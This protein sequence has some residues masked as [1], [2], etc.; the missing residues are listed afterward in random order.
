MR[1]GSRDGV[2]T[3]IEEKKTEEQKVEI[4]TPVELKT[5]P[6]I[7]LGASYKV[8]TPV[9]TAF[10]TVN[11]DEN[12]YPFE[13]FI[14]VGK[15]G[16]DITADAEALGRLISL[17]FRIPSAYSPKA[18]AEEVVLQLRG[19]GGS[20]SM[21]FGNGRVR[22]LADA[23]AKVLEEHIEGLSET[24]SVTTAVQETLSFN[25]KPKTILKKD[26]CPSCGQ[27]TLVYEEGCGKCYNC[28]F[29]KC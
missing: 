16:S 29:A 21:G 19:I 20:D 27:A 23:V 15:A 11:Q 7:L 14:N 4:A 28:G 13:I 22:S 17:A 8:K 18:V 12:G 26:I 24:P 3:H 9:G 25:Q 1:D 2:L 10:V 5:R 6:E